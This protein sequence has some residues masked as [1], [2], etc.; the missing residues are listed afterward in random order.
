[1]KKFF[2]AVMVIISAIFLVNVGVTEQEALAM[3][4]DQQAN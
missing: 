1:M 3:I 2:Y 4:P